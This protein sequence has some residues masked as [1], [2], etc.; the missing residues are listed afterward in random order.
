MPKHANWHKVWKL[1]V[2]SK[3]LAE[4]KSK[5]T[6]Q[7]IAA[8]RQMWQ[9]DSDSYMIHVEENFEFF[10]G[11]IKRSVLDY[12]IKNGL[13]H[14]TT[15]ISYMLSRSLSTAEH[16]SHG[17]AIASKLCYLPSSLLLAAWSF[18][19]S[20]SFCSPIKPK[21]HCTFTGLHR[22]MSATFLS[23]L[24]YCILQEF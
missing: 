12:C 22:H 7:I 16:L 4:G 6:H 11:Q 14:F 23:A 1:N 2:K 13:G 19:V 5:S 9:E 18:R 10:T 21:L 20:P 15:L 3:A 17:L 24:N 8:I